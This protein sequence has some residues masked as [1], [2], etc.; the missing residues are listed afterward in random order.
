M[1][2]EKFNDHILEGHLQ[3]VFKNLRLYPRCPLKIHNNFWVLE[4]MNFFLRK[5]QFYPSLKIS[6]L[7]SRVLE[8]IL[9]TIKLIDHRCYIRDDPSKIC[10]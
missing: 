5:P 8:N 9:I 10:I 2:P 1:I 3:N 7:S 4:N 6:I